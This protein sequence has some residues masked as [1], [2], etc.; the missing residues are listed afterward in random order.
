[1]GTMLAGRKSSENS[2]AS[3]NISLLKY[4]RDYFWPT[5]GPKV[6]LGYFPQA[7]M[8]MSVERI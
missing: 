6:C 1:M 5:K 4:K 7:R 8:S 3:R 2:S